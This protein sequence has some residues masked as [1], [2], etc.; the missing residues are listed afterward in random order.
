[1]NYQICG[2]IQ[3]IPL[4]KNIQEMGAEEIGPFAPEV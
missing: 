2:S 4:V 3:Y 1:M